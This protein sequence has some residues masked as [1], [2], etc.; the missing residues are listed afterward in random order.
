MALFHLPWDLRINS[1]TRALA[2]SNLDGKSET[3]RRMSG[4]CGA[5][6]G[7]GDFCEAIDKEWASY[8]RS[9]EVSGTSGAGSI[10]I[11]RSRAAEMA[12]ANIDPAELI[13]LALMPAVVAAIFRASAW[14]HYRQVNRDRP[15]SAYQR[16]LMKYGTLAVW[17]GIYTPFPCRFGAREAGWDSPHDGMGPGRVDPLP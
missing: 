12:S 13:A 14:V 6:G 8:N 1:T 17:R 5:R 16:C 11:A 2:D 15:L 4:S 10:P 7:G 3:S 9:I